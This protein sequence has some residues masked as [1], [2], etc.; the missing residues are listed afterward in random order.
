MAAAAR[1]VQILSSCATEAVYDIE[2]ASARRVRA[3]A[4]KSDDTKGLPGAGNANALNRDSRQRRISSLDVS[5]GV[6]REHGHVFTHPHESM[7]DL[8]RDIF[9]SAG[10]RREMF[11]YDCDAQCGNPLTFSREYPLQLALASKPLIRRIR[12]Q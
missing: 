9:D 10:A 12:L 2:G 11:D 7:S 5:V 4:R 1:T 6:S 8:P 3:R